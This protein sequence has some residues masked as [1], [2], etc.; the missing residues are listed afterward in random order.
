MSVQKILVT[1]AGSGLGKGAALGLARAGQRVIATTEAEAQHEALAREAK[2]AN[3]A[4]VIDRLNLLDPD[5]H[6]RIHALYG[7][8]V[9]ILVN[10]AAI[11]QTGPIAEVPVELVRRVFDVNVFGTLELTQLFANSF[12]RRGHGKI[13]FVSSIVGFSTFPFLAPYVASKHALEAIAQIMRQEMQPLGVQVATINPG[14]FQTGFNDRMIETM[15]GWYRPGSNFTPEKLIDEV[16]NL[17]AAQGFQLD[18]QDMIDFMVDL[19]PRAHHKFRN[20]FPED[21]VSPG[22]KYQSEVW[23]W[24]V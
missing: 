10:N 7:E 22:K 1:G 13:F 20:V 5:D 23:E 12:A 18:P 16:R 21:F 17:F 2:A 3:V 19:I 6:S 8:E 4:L 24:E 11:G 14:P 9:D 15:K